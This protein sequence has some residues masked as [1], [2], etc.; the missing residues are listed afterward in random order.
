MEIAR[1][2]G[3]VFKLRAS[4]HSRE[5]GLFLSWYRIRLGRYSDHTHTLIVEIIQ[6]RRVAE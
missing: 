4:E 6:P 5:E 1:E 3:K 2:E